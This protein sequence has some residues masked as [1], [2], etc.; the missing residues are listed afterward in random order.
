MQMRSIHILTGV[1]FLA[2][3]SCDTTRFNSELGSE[4]D[5]GNFGNPT[6]TN[7][8]LM[9]GKLDASQALAT[10]FADQLPMIVL[11]EWASFLGGQIGDGH[12]AWR[13]TLMSGLIPAIPLIVIRPFLPESPAWAQKRAAGTLDVGAMRGRIRVWPSNGVSPTSDS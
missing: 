4:V 3:A 11:P 6:M 5:E 9:T 10:R 13:Y 1:A 2:L 12:A 8:M 7:A